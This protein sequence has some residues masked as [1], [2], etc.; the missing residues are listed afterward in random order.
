MTEHSVV[1]IESSDDY[2]VTTDGRTM[3]FELKNEDDFRNFMIGISTTK[4]RHLAASK[5]LRR[6]EVM[7][8]EN[9]LSIFTVSFGG[10]AHRLK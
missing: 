5:T 8:M 9:D 6:M 2:V 1:E 7:K 4:K 10:E 3:N